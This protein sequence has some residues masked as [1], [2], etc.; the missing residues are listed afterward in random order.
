MTK[1]TPVIPKP[2]NYNPS[3]WG[4]RLLIA[5]VAIVAF[6]ISAY[7]GLFQLGFISGV[8]DPVFGG[9]SEAVLTSHVSET[10]HRYM[11]I[12][13]A[14]LGSL[15]YLGDALLVLA[16]STRRWQYRP[17]LVATFGIV[18]I[19]LGFVS[20]ILVAM[21]GAVLHLWCFL[22]LVSAVFSI[23]LIFLAV[24]EVI[25]T[26]YYL[27]R[28]WKISGDRCLLWH[29]FWGRPSKSAHAAAQSMIRPLSD[30]GPNP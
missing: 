24:D 5:A 20:L 14:I 22:C 25:S 8:W 17:W 2:W 10:M 26:G 12:P 18:A 3:R 6:G 19:P 13:D 16:G 1:V 28:V 27:V 7:M 21:Q 23:V 30:V 9:Q 15:A 29:T 11:R 4:E